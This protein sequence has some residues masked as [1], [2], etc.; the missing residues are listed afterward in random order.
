MYFVPF[1]AIPSCFTITNPAMNAT[2][3]TINPENMIETKVV[4]NKVLKSVNKLSTFSYH[5]FHLP[6]RAASMT[7][8][9]IV[10][11][12]QQSKQIS[13]PVQQYLTSS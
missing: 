12:G 5:K 10:I 13:A 1:N 11:S 4:C 8:I 2:S 7:L 9:A 3:P 6:L